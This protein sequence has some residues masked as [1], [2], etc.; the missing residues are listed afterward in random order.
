MK[1]PLP[2]RD[3][4]KRRWHQ[5]SLRSLLVFV[6]LCAAFLSWFG[7]WYRTRTELDARDRQILAVIGSLKDNRPPT[8]TKS[9]WDNTVTWTECL[10]GNS[11]LP[12]EANL[13]DLRRFHRELKEKTKGEV[14]MTTILWIWD[15]VAQ[16]T[17]S[18]KRYQR[19]RQQML[20]EIG[21]NESPNNK[22]TKHGTK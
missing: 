12:F 14:D 11:L 7:W 3:F 22:E 18:G 9:Q 19:F 13:D 1:Q 6:T 16:L 2:E 17:P 21:D 20:D 15:R 10:E 4:P 5:Y 8:M